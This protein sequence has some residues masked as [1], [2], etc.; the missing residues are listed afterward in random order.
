MTTTYIALLRGINVG[1]HRVS[2]EALRQHLAALGLQRV[3]TYIQTGNVFFDA[4]A[5]LDRAQLTAR[6]EQHLQQALGYA[7]PTF[8]R[9]TDELAQLLALQPFGPDPA[10]DTQRR[11]LMLLAQPAPTDLVLPHR[12]PKGEYEIVH[13]T[14]QEA[15]VVWHLQDGRPPSSTT[16]LDKTLGKLTT[17]RFVHTAVKILE[18]ARQ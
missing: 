15:F 5:D 14:G 6:I 10:P 16:F 9:T 18:A 17:T 4:P 2:M 1:G 8:L 7:V 11:C 13:L 3:R 12:S